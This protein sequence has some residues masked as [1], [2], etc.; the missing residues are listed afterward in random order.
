M[1]YI[2]NKNFLELKH[3]IAKIFAFLSTVGNILLWVAA[4]CYHC[5]SNFSL[6]CTAACSFHRPQKFFSFH[7]LRF[8]LSSLL[9]TASKT[10]PSFISCMGPHLLHGKVSCF[11]LFLSLV[12]NQLRKSGSFLIQ[13]SVIELT[14]HRTNQGLYIS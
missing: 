4:I 8:R 13:H 11:V 10:K 5:F 12:S 14:C 3:S 2:Y 6:S 1:Y 9:C 7:L